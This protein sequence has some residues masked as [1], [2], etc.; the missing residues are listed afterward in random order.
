MLKGKYGENY[1]NLTFYLLGINTTD[2]C[3]VLFVE[4]CLQIAASNFLS[5]W[6]IFKNHDDYEKKL[7]DFS[8]K[9]SLYLLYIDFCLSLSKTIQKHLKD[10][11]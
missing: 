7:V 11:G 10:L 3:N 1:S 2:I 4:Q 8:L 5:K 6:V 9:R